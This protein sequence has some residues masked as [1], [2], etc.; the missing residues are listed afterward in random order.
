[1]FHLLDTT[2]LIAALGW[3]LHNLADIAGRLFK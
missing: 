2:L 3:I 1:M